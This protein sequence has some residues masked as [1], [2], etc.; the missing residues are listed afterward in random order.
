MVTKQPWHAWGCKPKQ[1]IEVV[2][3]LLASRADPCI[4][5]DRSNTVLMDMCG[6]GNT[7]TFT[8]VYLRIL[9]GEFRE[10]VRK[11]NMYGRNL[12]SIGGLA[13]VDERRE[14]PHV[15]LE[16]L[17]MVQHLFELGILP[18]GWRGKR[19]HKRRIADNG[20]GGKRVANPP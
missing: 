8:Y 2:E 15:E 18:E 5:G 4:T 14:R 13:D 12:Y 19:G 10:L 16:C 9:A 20:K 6:A 17:L 3:S 1:Q 11:E 7:N